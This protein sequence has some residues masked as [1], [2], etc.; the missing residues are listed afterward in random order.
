MHQEARVLCLF[1]IA[2]TGKS[3]GKSMAS[4]NL[5]CN[6]LLLLA[7]LASL[8]PAAHYGAVMS[9][10]TFPST[11]NYACDR[12]PS[13]LCHLQMPQPSTIC[14]SMSWGLPLTLG[15][16]TWGSVST[17]PGVLSSLAASGCLQRACSLQPVRDQARAWDTILTDLNSCRQKE[18][19][20]DSMLSQCDSPQRDLVSGKL[21]QQKKGCLGRPGIR[22][23]GA[24]C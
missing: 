16:S 17:G 12:T 18:G 21:S 4:T 10:T 13:V 7:A 3:W 14:Q 23:K 15:G 11:M 24:A 8:W 5:S 2:M 9:H 1:C 22:R 20:K 19:L 6:S